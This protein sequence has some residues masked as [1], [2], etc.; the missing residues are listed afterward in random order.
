L[1]IGTQVGLVRF[2]GVRFVPWTPT[3]GKLL[4]SSLITS[5][6]GAR[7]GSLWIGT[8]AGLVQWK[9]GD[10]I[11]FPETTGRIN[12]IYEDRDGTIW[13]GRSRNPAGGLCRV[14]ESRAICYGPKDGLPQFSGPVVGD[15]AGNVWVGSP[16][17]VTRWKAGSATKYIP[18]GLTSGGLNG[19]NALAVARDGSI[20]V[21][22]T[23]PGRGLGLQ[24]LEQGAWK[25]FATPAFDGSTLN[26]NSLRLDRE[27]SLWIG[28]EGSGLYRVHDGKVDHFGSA[29]GLSSDSVEFFFEDTEGNLWVATAEG[30]DRFRE[31][32]VINFSTHEGLSGDKVVSVLASRDGT[33]WIGNRTGVDAVRGEIISSIGPKNG[34]PGQRV[35]AMLEDHAGR[36]WIGVDNG[37]F[38]CEG[39]EFKPV[40]NRDGKSAGTVI[41]MTEDVEGNIWAETVTPRRLLRIQD[42]EVREEIPDPQIPY[43]PTLAADPKD[44][45]WLGFISG[46]GLARYQKGQL[47]T[48][49]LNQSPNARVNQLIVDSDG[50]V[51]VATSEGLIK[52]R[53]GSL[54]TLT[55]RNGLPCNAIHTII[56][57]KHSDLWMYTECGLIEIASDQLQKWLEQPDA[58]IN[59]KIFDVF[60]GAQPSLP[61]FRPAATRSTDGRLWFANEKVVQVIDPEKLLGNPTPPPVLVEDVIA[62]RKRYSPSDG[63]R[64]PALTRDLEIDYTALSLVVPQKVRFRYKLEGYDSDWQDAQ[65]RR[66][67]F[68]TRLHPGTYRF[69]VIACNNDGVWNETGAALEFIIAPAFYQT[70]WFLALS[71][72]GALAGIYLL[73]LLRLRQVTH[74]VRVR[75]EER[76][77]E[78]ERIARDLHDTLLQSVQ[79]LILK[80]HAVAKQIPTHE[81]AHHTMETALDRADEVVAEGRDRVRN[82]RG[83]VSLNAL[84]S[85]FE[86]VAEENSPGGETSFKTVV[87]GD[88]R[89]LHPMVLEE[90]YSIG[91]EALINALTHSHGRHIEVEISY[92]PRQF[93]L[94]VR[95]DGH[96]IDPRILEEGGRTDHWGLRGM[97]ERAERI[98]AELKIWSSHQT[99]TEVGLIVPASTAYQNVRVKSN[100][101]WFRRAKESIRSDL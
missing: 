101:P 33:V 92:E 91:R 61:P 30:I 17:T 81:P 9:N 19:I 84:P 53:S 62:D 24:Q 66:Q 11:S 75:L 54:H 56:F 47:E 63:L 51:L 82:L 76:L 37:L 4:P 16:E 14:T 5:L 89:E 50:S 85:A 27:N 67:A 32:R 69:R 57:D 93:R 88:V 35:T 74:Q 12:S 28:T 41:A 2:D 87:E 10:L 97:R 99:G 29:D 60:D 72:A 49:P 65:T 26:V 46:G 94:R 15:D 86:R 25:T 21:G 96:G 36:L 100:R 42:R 48:F 20:F 73:Y 52:W 58:T 38:I 3:D 40:K 77:N 79:G 80:F 18:S 83:A 55:V 31:S 45:I 98:G 8:G 39:G 59:V 22:I 71:V 34:L 70:S 78:R 90:S 68:Y 64:L 23:Q 43:A 7:D 6:L 95:D 13:A 44:G 1:W